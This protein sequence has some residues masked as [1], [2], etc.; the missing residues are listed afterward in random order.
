[1]ASLQ[2][3][4]LLSDDDEPEVIPETQI[5]VPESRHTLPRPIGPTGPSEPPAAA[6][7]T[8]ESTTAEPPA[9]L[10]FMPLPALNQQYT[11]I[12]V[13]V[14]TINDFART[15]GYAV[16]ISRSKRTKRGVKK[17]V[18]LRCDRGRTPH[19]RLGHE[20]KRQRTSLATGC[21]FA[22]S[23][24]LQHDTNIWHLTVENAGHNHGPSPP[25]THIIHRKRELDT[26]AAEIRK[27]LE[28]GLTARQIIS[29][30]RANDPTSCLQPLDIY[31]M[32]RQLNRESGIP[33]WS[34]ASPSVD[35]GA[36]N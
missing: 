36:T 21:P 30:A 20:R 31:N 28:Q 24:R 25:E 3:D 13:A 2:L 7:T 19:D 1:M 34:Y 33:G 16:S 6:L 8:A 32:R 14:R 17:T 26:K 5:S 9:T 29:I 27:Q 10:I 35:D 15:H 11:D 12:K 4:Y 23:L 18:R 22:I